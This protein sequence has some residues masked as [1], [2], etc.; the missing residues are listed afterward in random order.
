MQWNQ[1]KTLFILCFLILDIFL[2]QQFLSVIDS[3]A[4]SESNPYSSQEEVIKENI[5]GLDNLPG[6]TPKDSFI[7]FKA[8]DFTEDD[9]TE[10]TARREQ[11]AFI[12]SDGDLLFSQFKEPIP[13]EADSTKSEKEVKVTENMLFGSEYVYWGQD[14]V[15]GALIFFQTNNS[16]PIYYSQSGFIAAFVNKDNEITSYIQA[17]LDEVDRKEPKS[18]ISAFK[19]V[20]NLY[21]AGELTLDSE[22]TEQPEVGYY[23]FVDLN[24]GQQVFIPSW[25][26]TINESKHYVVMGFEGQFSSHDNPMFIR[27]SIR[28]AQD[29]LRTTL[30]EEEDM[31]YLRNTFSDLLESTR[32]SGEE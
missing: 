20:S 31:D 19:A 3:R 16:K 12:L 9:L 2:L 29:G 14:E 1:I 18:M 26:I 27:N 13:I 15:T 7:T 28:R 5:K 6:E 4:P 32:V 21:N 10:L 17:A 25:D 8:R 23:S 30:L 24:E 22:I 11:D